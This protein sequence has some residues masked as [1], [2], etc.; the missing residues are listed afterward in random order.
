[1]WCP[2]Y[3]IWPVAV[4]DVDV[5]V[6]SKIMMSAIKYGKKQ[7]CKGNKVLLASQ[8]VSL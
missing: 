8:L 3:C 5:S 6:N 4:T 7:Y 2:W 1:M